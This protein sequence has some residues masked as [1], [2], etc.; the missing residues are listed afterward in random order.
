MNKK[1]F[2]VI[3]P[4]ALLFIAVFASLTPLAL[5][6][7]TY[8]F[9]YVTHGTINGG[10]VGSPSNI[11]GTGPDNNWAQI[12]GSV[13]NRGGWIIGG[14]SAP[15]T[16]GSYICVYAKCAAGYTNSLL[17]V[18]VSSS[19]YGTYYLAGSAVISTTSGTWYYFVAPAY[20][21]PFRYIYVQGLGDAPVSIFIDSILTM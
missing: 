10:Y 16:A 18:Y 12:H 7:P 13:P 1:K 8:L 9:S 4:I 2:L 21:N 17:S 11:V 20:P 15:V 14:M 19:A 3:S 6:N 5:A